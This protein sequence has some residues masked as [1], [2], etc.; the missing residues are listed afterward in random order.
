MDGLDAAE[1]ASRYTR[2]VTSQENESMV[3]SNMKMGESWIHTSHE[4]SNMR[5]QRNQ[6]TVNWSMLGIKQ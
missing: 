3:G 4:Q 5:Q 6:R 2:L 1:V